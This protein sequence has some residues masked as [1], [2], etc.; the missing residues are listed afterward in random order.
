MK[1]AKP[2]FHSDLKNSMMP[3]D[4]TSLDTPGLGPRG[5]FEGLV[6]LNVKFSA[7]GDLLGRW[8]IGKYQP[9]LSGIS[10]WLCY[11][12][13]AMGNGHGYRNRENSGNCSSAFGGG[14]HVLSTANV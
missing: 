6:Q 14:P 3:L 7:F 4:G 5:W 2:C 13:W 1:I 10:L 11:T 12:P 9:P 8:V